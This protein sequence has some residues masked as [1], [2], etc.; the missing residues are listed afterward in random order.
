MLIN[1][2]I[3]QQ[4]TYQQCPCISPRKPVLTLFSVQSVFGL[5]RQQ[6]IRGSLP[7]MHTYSVTSPFAWVNNHNNYSYRDRDHFSF[8]Y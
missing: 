7:T 4:T 2:V 6:V 8:S 1:I 3:L 5:P